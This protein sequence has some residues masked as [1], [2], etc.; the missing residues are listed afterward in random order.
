MKLTPGFGV[1]IVKDNGV[2]VLEA[3]DEAFI[4]LSLIAKPDRGILV[5]DDVITV[6]SW[7]AGVASY[8]VIGW[9]AE[10]RAL[11]CRREYPPPGT[12]PVGV[13]Q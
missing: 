8:R 2:E 3:A 4:S 6:G 7:G 12:E 10:R 9:D 13:P 11:L 5:E 1:I